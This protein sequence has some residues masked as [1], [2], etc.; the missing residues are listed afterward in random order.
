M[1]EE[2]VEILLCADWC[3]INQCV[4]GSLPDIESCV[5][6]FS[7]E[8]V[9]FGLWESLQLSYFSQGFRDLTEVI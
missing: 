5:S 9:R 1:L 6:L 2:K 4:E 3:G 8:D 7:G